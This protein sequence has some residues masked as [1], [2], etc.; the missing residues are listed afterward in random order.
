MGYKYS[1]IDNETYGTDDINAAISRL[2]TSGVTIC[3]TDENLINAMND[4]T[5]EVA[6]DGVEYDPASC[7]V[8]EGDEGFIE[9]RKGTAFFDDGVTITIDEEGIVIPKENGSYVYLYHDIESNSCYA[10]TSAELPDMRCVLLAY[11][12]DDGVITDKRKYATSKLAPNSPHN[13]YS[14]KSDVFFNTFIDTGDHYMFSINVGHPN[15][16]YMGF[17][18]SQWSTMGIG[19]FGEDGYTPY[20]KLGSEHRA[21]IRFKKV[22][23]VAEMYLKQNND[24]NYTYGVEFIAF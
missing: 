15:F 14:Y 23:T 10:K 24:A 8:T 16:T 21:T 1:F 6:S 11:I 13:F 12:D 18:N 22:D 20:M 4:V 7:T 19:K 5:S 3:P 2:T 17:N 9:I